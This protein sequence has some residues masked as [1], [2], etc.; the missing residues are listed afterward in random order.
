MPRTAARAAADASPARDPRRRHRRGRANP[1][2]MSASDP[3]ALGT[4]GYVVVTG[5][6]WLDALYMT[7]IT[8]S[9]VGFAEVVPLGPE[10]RVFTMVLIVAGVGT[11]F[12]ILT[13]VAE[14]VVDGRLRAIVGRTT[15]QHTIEQLRHHVV[16]CGYGRLGRVVVAELRRG[17]VPVVVVDVDPALAPDLEEL[18]IP[19]VIGSALSE[20][21]LARAGLARARA[22]AIAT[23]SD[24]DN[25]FITLSAREKHPGLRIHA[26]AETDA[27]V[28]HLRLAGA[29]QV[30]SAYHTGG[31]RLAASILRPTV[32]DFLE[33]TGPEG[34]EEVDLGEVRAEPRSA[35]VGRTLAAIEGDLTRLRIVAVRRGDARMSLVPGPD[36]TIRDG[37]VLVAIGARPSL[38]ALA[39]AAQAH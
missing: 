25:V 37:D 20:A 21:V 35:L 26:R 34:P 36:E 8:I 23:P 1:P 31:L 14:L 12:Y 9:T 13:S 32:I 18:R 30:L 39:Q 15:M 38:A 2:P 7:V 28:R 27:G 24:A 10:G 17:G 16:V 3:T 4:V 33:L 22:I 5:A 6:S 19:H 11:A 29:H